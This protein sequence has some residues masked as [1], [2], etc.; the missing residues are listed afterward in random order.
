[1]GEIVSGNYS[2]M[3]QSRFRDEVLSLAEPDS[4]FEADVLNLLRP[5]AEYDDLVAL[6]W[7]RD[8]DVAITLGQVL[9]TRN[10]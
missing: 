1:M 3:F 6:I 8:F 4:V 9:G 7:D 2:V 10:R 5:E